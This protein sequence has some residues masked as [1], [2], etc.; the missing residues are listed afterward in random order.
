MLAQREQ[1]RHERIALVLTFSLGVELSTVVLPGLEQTDERKHGNTPDIR[2]N[3]CN[4]AYERSCREP[5]MPLMEINGI[6]VEF[7]QNLHYVRNALTQKKSLPPLLVPIVGP[8][9]PSVV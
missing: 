7:A 2:S 6:R 8:F 5:L 9:S 4:M 3:P 1:E